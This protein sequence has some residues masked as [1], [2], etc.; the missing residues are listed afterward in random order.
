MEGLT[1][2]HKRV[3]GIDVHRMLHVVTVFIEHPDGRIE[4]T[5]HEYSG[6]QRQC[7]ELTAWL[8]KLQIEL[9]VMETKVSAFKEIT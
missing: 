2:V 4:Q 7:R 5:T 3:A 9:V 1:S 6:V 8:V